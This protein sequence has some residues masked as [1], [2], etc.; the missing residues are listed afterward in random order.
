MLYHHL[1]ENPI[2]AVLVVQQQNSMLLTHISTSLLYQ[3]GILHIVDN[4]QE[5]SRLVCVDHS[6]ELDL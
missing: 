3:V 1:T 4:T 6:N 2:D 5:S